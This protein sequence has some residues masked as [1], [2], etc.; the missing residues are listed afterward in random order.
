MTNAE[1]FKNCKYWVDQI[2]QYADENVV[3]AL[4]GNKSDSATL[5]AYKRKVTLN[6]AKQFAEENNLLFVGETSSQMNINVKEVFDALY[7][8]KNEK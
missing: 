2:R 5:A 8:S 1:S 6:N 4:V 7:E 3:I